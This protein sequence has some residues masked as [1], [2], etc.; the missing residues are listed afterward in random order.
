M[1]HGS[2]YRRRKT[3]SSGVRKPCCPVG[4]S[5]S[6]H[7]PGQYVRKVAVPLNDEPA[8]YPKRKLRV[9][10]FG[11]GYSGLIFAHKLQNVRKEADAILEHIIFKAKVSIGGT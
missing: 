1:Y 3:L 5:V 4:H 9:I 11:A 7:A 10:I 6:S 8:F 2:V